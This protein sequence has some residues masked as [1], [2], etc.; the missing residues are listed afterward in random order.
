MTL[1]RQR[2][3]QDVQIRNLADN[4]QKGSVALRTVGREISI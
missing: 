1:L 4:T 3:L 2:M